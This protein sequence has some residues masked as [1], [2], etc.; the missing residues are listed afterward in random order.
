MDVHPDCVYLQTT[1]V[2]GSE[3]PF[4]A[5]RELAYRTLVGLTLP[6]PAEGTVL[7]KANATVLYGPETRIITHPGFLGGMLDALGEKGVVGRR[8]AVGDGQGGEHPEKGF[9]WKNAGYADVLGERGAR[10]AAMD[11]TEAQDVEVPAGV[12]Y[13][14]FPI[15]REVTDCAFLFNVPVA[16][17][18]NL[19]CTTLAMK[20]LMGTVDRPIRHLCSVQEIDKP[21]AA[22]YDLLT[23]EGISLHEE[24]FC[25]KL[26]D[27]LAAV[28]SLGI[29][30]LSV[31][32][33]LVGRDGTA[34]REGANHAL[35]WS[36]AGENEVHVDAV[37]T[38]LMGLDP[39]RTPYLRTA[40]SRGLGTHRVEEI[41]VR[42]LETGERLG[43]DSLAAAR[44]AI[45]MMPLARGGS[46]YYARFRDDG[47][48]VPWRIDQVN[49]RRMAEG[50]APLPVP[51]RR[52]DPPELRRERA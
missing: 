2:Q 45:T 7:L 27:L 47:S 4:E 49:A 31:V 34:F 32:D 52:H 21:L 38:Y 18:H 24:R 11:R 51:W 15:Y 33:G 10:L 46:G 3:A 13:E 22:D 25:H 12:V 42:D 29:P 17:C 43:A 40:A 6:L 9:T 50:E 26:C 5:Y 14:R 36:L 35:G 16:K 1:H 30:R 28:R 39:V 48:L 23:S 44:S 19:V 41:P 8:L 20:N 37:G